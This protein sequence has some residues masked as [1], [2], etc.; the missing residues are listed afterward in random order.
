MPGQYSRYGF[1]KA[2]AEMETGE[3]RRDE[4]LLLLL[5]ILICLYAA[6]LGASGFY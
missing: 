4:A 6:Y 1:G 5:R 3:S 2:L